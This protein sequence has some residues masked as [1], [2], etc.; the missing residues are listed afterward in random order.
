MNKQEEVDF[1]DVVE[2]KDYILEVNVDL[3]ASILEELDTRHSAPP[4]DI[5]ASVLFR[6]FDEY[7][8][9]YFFYLSIHLHCA[10]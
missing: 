7:S 6:D 5:K 1:Q 4:G 3:Q 9:C 10:L 8:A 2:D